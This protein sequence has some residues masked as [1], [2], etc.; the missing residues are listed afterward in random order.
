MVNSL[1]LFFRNSLIS[2]WSCSLVS[3]DDRILVAAFIWFWCKTSWGF[4]LNLPCILRK[5]LRD[6]FIW[7][8]E[9]LCGFQLIIWVTR[10][11]FNT[12]SHTLCSTVCKF[13]YNIYIQLHL[14]MFRWLVYFR[15]VFTFNLVTFFHCCS[16]VVDPFVLNLQI[17]FSDN[18][19]VF[20]RWVVSFLHWHIQYFLSH[21]F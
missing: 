2:W 10:L 19:C 18:S 16:F 15:G 17:Y 1:W 20:I 4:G 8:S 13:L 14:L 7:V 21:L 12:H 5:I 9:L 6:S 11:G 3:I